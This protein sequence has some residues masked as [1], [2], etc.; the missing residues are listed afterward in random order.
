M[1]GLSAYTRFSLAASCLSSLAYLVGEQTTAV[2]PGSALAIVLKTLP[3]GLLVLAALTTRLR[4]SGMQALVLALCATGDML[5]EVNGGFQWGAASFALGHLVATI[6]LLRYR[7]T[8]T[9]PRGLAA[10]ALMQI[11]LLAPI[12]F[13][14]PR[15][16]EAFAMIYGLSIALMTGALIVS[17]FPRRAAWGAIVF[18]VSDLLIVINLTAPVFGPQLDG[19]LIWTG[20]Y[21]AQC[22]IFAGINA[23]LRAEP[24]AR[25][26]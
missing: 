20:Y 8:I 15:V 19:I 21:V 23:G 5:L 12:V 6:W 13:K 18:M 3:V 10:A 25:R 14:Q 17:R 11:A 26:R 22:M 7:A 24:Q 16:P 1:S 9:A 4:G 2:V